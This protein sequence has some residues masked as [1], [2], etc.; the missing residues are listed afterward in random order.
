MNIQAY[1]S[2]RIFG[3]DLKC[4][5]MLRA[6]EICNEDM[7]RSVWFPSVR[8]VFQPLLGEPPIYPGMCDCSKIFWR[9]LHSQ[10]QNSPVSHLDIS[11]IKDWKTKPANG[12]NAL[13][14]RELSEVWF[15]GYQD[16]CF[17]DGV[18]LE[19]RER[20]LMG[21]D[22]MVW[23]VMVCSNTLFFFFIF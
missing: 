17:P 19:R 3:D 7:I 20:V 12:P 11:W 18:A 4:K 6:P 5:T 13:A 16:G 14:Q 22:N 2:W 8:Q 23:C 21:Q 1:W 10:D 15:S 9:Q